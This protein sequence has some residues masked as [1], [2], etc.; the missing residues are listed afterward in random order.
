MFKN[1]VIF[2]IATMFIFNINSYELMLISNF[3]NVHIDK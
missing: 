2:G 1:Q 3:K